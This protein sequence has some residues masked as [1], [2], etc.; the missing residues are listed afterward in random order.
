[1]FDAFNSVFSLTIAENGA[2]KSSRITLKILKTTKNIQYNTMLLTQVITC[3][4][5]EPLK[6][7]LLV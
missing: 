5:Q 4:V 6:E 1:M 3:V 2:Q 7:S